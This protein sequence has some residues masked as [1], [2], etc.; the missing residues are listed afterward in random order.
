MVTN[1]KGTELSGN[2]YI[3]V[4]MRGVPKGKYNSY[5]QVVAP[6]NCLHGEFIEG[7]DGTACETAECL[8][9]WSL[10]YQ[11]FLLRTGRGRRIIDRFHL[12]DAQVAMLASPQFREITRE[13]DPFDPQYDYQM[14]YTRRKTEN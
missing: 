14:N 4:Q 3:T 13:L 8:N 9:S 1:F 12:T 11:F 5:L 2:A 7:Q 10:D 6:R